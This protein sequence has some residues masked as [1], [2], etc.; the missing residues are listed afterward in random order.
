VNAWYGV[1]APAATPAATI[2]RINREINEVIKMPDVRDK[3]MA[4]GIEVAGGTPQVLEGFMKAD[5]QRYGAL[6]RE[7]SIKAD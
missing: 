4:A 7:L 1:F 6:A 3:L 2:A 5:N